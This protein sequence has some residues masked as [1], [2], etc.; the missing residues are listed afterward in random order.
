MCTA[1]VAERFLLLQAIT[2]KHKGTGGNGRLEFRALI[3]TMY[4]YDK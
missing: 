4:Q 3:A 1:I 2:V